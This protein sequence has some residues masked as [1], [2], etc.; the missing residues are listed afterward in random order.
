M[1]TL[2]GL[3][4]VGF[5]KDLIGADFG[6]LEPF[7]F[8]RCQRG[9]IDIDPADFIAAVF[10]VINSLDGLQDIVKPLFSL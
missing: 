3:A 4:V 9:D 8:I 6:A 7:E 5:L 1:H 10:G 2:V